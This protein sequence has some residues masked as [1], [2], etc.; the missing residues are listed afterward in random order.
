MLGEYVFVR[1][2]DPVRKIRSN[3][4]AVYKNNTGR[5]AMAKLMDGTKKNLDYY[6][7]LKEIRTF[8]AIA[9]LMEN[10]GETIRKKF[11]D[12]S[13]SAYISH[14]WKNDKVILLTE[15]V[16][17]KTLESAPLETKV[18]MTEKVLAFLSEVGKYFNH[19]NNFPLPYRPAL[20]IILIFFSVSLISVVRHPVLLGKILRSI[21]IFIR[22]LPPLLTY[23][24]MTFVHRGLE[25]HNMMIDNS[26]ITILDLEVAAK[27]IDLIDPIHILLYSW[28]DQPFFNA[29]YQSQ[30]MKNIRN[31]RKK[32][33]VFRALSLYAA[34]HQIATGYERDREMYLQFL[35]HSLKV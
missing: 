3:S 11:P 2:F 32:F 16:E 14:V 22:T 13:F 31:D 24:H 35:D 20:Y 29:F 7:F 27:T 15:M 10:F 26:H 12:V 1:T 25:H 21:L 33:Q 19:S 17:G 9:N 30:V 23:G 4:F 6:Q 28:D 18:Q 8:Q 5:Y 34:L